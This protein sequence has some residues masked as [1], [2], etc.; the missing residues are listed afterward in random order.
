MFNQ[1]RAIRYNPG[2]ETYTKKIVNFNKSV[3]TTHGLLLFYRIALY[4]FLRLVYE[5]HWCHFTF[6]FGISLIG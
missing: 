1:Q 5:N 3:V 4:T 2:D 6:N